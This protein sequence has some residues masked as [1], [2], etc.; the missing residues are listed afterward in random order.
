MYSRTEFKLIKKEN[1]KK[2]YWYC[3]QINKRL[4]YAIEGEL[5]TEGK[6]QK[7]Q[8]NIFNKVEPLISQKMADLKAEGFE[9]CAYEQF[10]LVL[11]ESET[12]DLSFENI[13]ELLDDSIDELKD[14]INEY[15]QNRGLVSMHSFGIYDDN[16]GMRFF[17]IDDQ[18]TSNIISQI[19]KERIEKLKLE[20]SNY[21][22][23]QSN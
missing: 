5:G 8:T 3:L 10:D 23:K 9:A 4:A 19:F 6:E 18:L 14:E 12:E 1:G 22:N 7:F 17:T 21:Y 2:Y 15:L 13:P 11:F 16:L 20:L